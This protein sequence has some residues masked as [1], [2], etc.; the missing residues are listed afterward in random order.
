MFLGATKLR[1]AELDLLL[2][3]ACNVPS[4]FASIKE[5]AMRRIACCRMDED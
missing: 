2:M 1:H 3:N 5:F 4:T